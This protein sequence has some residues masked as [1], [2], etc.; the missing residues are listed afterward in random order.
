MSGVI[1]N[2]SSLVIVSL[3]LFRQFFPRS[4]AL[5]LYFKA[6]LWSIVIASGIHDA[7]SWNPAVLILLSYDCMFSILCVLF[8]VTYNKLEPF[9]A[10]PWVFKI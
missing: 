7:Q 10:E 6:S 2:S 4:S 5:P 3:G 9:F 8:C 1:I